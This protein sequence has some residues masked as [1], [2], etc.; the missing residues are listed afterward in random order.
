MLLQAL[1]AARKTS[2]PQPTFYSNPYTPTPTLTQAILRVSPLLT[3]LVIVRKWLH[4]TVAQ[5]S[6]PEATTLEF[7]E[8]YARTKSKNVYDASRGDSRRARSRRDEQE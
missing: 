1:M 3:E 7:Y 8:A 6:I 5:P 2:A 4:D